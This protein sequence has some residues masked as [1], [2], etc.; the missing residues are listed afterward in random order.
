M[1]VIS[2]SKRN[3][4]EIIRD[5]LSLVFCLGL[6]L[7]LLIIFQQ[8]KIPNEA[9]NIENFTAGTVV[10]SLAFITMFT[11][12]LVAK[13][14]ST[15]LLT[16]LFISPMNAFEYI[17]G[18]TLSVLPVVIIQC[19]LFFGAAVIMGLDFS[20]KIILCSIISVLMS[21]M[22]IMLGIFIGCITNEKSSSG[23][24]SII[25][26]LVAFTSGMYFPCELLGKGFNTV[27]KIL[28]FLHS[29][30]ILKNIINGTSSGFFADIMIYFAYTVIFTFL[31]VIIFNYKMKN[32]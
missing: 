28:P 1:R 3:F 10:F 9:F 4:K 2:F 32:Q 5:P 18:Y 8:I 23:L 12:V 16:R 6:P 17:S 29:T 24:S 21:I 13:D 7:A 20:A 25:V 27:C 22:F 30:D 11:A 14:R 31:A 26:Q 15:S 19:I